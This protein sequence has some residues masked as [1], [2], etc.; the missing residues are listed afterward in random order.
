L[1]RHRE[2]A[3]RMAVGAEPSLVVR[4]LMWKIL[5]VLTVGVVVGVGSSLAAWRAFES[6]LFEISAADPVTIMLAVIGITVVAVGASFAP[7]ARAARIN[8]VDLLA[9]D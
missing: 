5:R 3:I 7:L 2:I 4:A 9:T 6:Q 1:R 8:P